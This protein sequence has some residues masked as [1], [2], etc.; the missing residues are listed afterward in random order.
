MKVDLE[1]IVAGRGTMEQLDLLQELGETITD[2]PFGM[3][4]G[5]SGI[6]YQIYL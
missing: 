4:S 3:S 1:D 5:G 2:M 6:S